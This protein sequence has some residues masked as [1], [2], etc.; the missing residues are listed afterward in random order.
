MTGK[1][2]DGTGP[3][4]HSPPGT[5]TISDERMLAGQLFNETWRLLDR[6]N[7]DQADDDR[8]LYAAYAARYHW[9]QVPDATPAHLARGEWQVSRVCAVLGRA[10]PA[11][12][13]ARRVLEICQRNGIGD[14][15]LAFGY[16]ALARGCVV[17][18]DTAAAREAFGQAVAAVAGIAAEE[19]RELLLSDLAT[20]PGGLGWLEEGQVR[21][22]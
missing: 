10:E 19:D 22:V 11:V 12:F 2:P 6:A 4:T 5:G 18:G 7:R 1:Q 13:H 20:I 15:D 3:T 9:G 17:A 21:P 8:M 14:F 16:E